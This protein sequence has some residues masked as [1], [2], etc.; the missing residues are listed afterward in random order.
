MSNL[1]W[2]LLSGFLFI[3][4]SKQWLCKEISCIIW[5][6]L[7]KPT[8]IQHSFWEISLFPRIALPV[9]EGLGFSW[10]L[11]PYH[12]STGPLPAPPK[13]SSRYTQYPSTLPINQ[14]EI[15]LLFLFHEETADQLCL[16]SEIKATGKNAETYNNEKAY[17]FAQK[18]LL[19]G[20]PLKSWFSFFLN[21]CSFFLK[22]ILS[23]ISTVYK[24]QSK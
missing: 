8:C 12:S 17:I 20:I 18:Y 11:A 13:R 4:L 22:T 19:K 16:L 1:H 2:C 15:A 5:H 24:T 21:T 7:N 3:L 10:F 9:S 23:L 6:T 14:M